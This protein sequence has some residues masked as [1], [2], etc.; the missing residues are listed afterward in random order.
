VSGTIC[1]LCL[2]PL[3]SEL[4]FRER[5]PSMTVSE[6]KFLGCSSR[7]FVAA[8][9]SVSHRYE[10]AAHAC[11]ANSGNWSGEWISG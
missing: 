10:I 3:S 8:A 4:D 5:I 7:P 11:A 2:G 9:I 1:H 6:Q